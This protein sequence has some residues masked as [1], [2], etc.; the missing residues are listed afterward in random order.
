M[1]PLRVMDEDKKYIKIT[2][3]AKPFVNKLIALYESNDVFFVGW[4]TAAIIFRQWMMPCERCI[5]FV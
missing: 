1:W 5:Y 3:T 4:P 2:V